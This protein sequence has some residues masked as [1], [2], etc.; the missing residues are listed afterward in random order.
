MWENRRRKRRRSVDKQLGD[1][2][3]LEQRVLLSAGQTSPLKLHKG[4]LPN[5]AAPMVV[6]VSGRWNV[7]DVYLDIT[8]HGFKV[9][10]FFTILGVDAQFKIH[11]KE[12]YV[13]AQPHLAFKGKGHYL[14]DQKAK[15]TVSSLYDSQVSGEYLDTST[16]LTI[17]KT[18][19][20]I[21]QFNSLKRV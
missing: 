10:G 16:S 17:L 5:T 12:D 18:G 9:K 2:I 7:G 4:D 15:I 21:N 13:G 8:Q 6:D 20:E 19:T 14:T 11:G 3:M 1:P